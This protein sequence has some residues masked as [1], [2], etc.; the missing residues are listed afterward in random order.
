FGIMETAGKSVTVRVTLTYSYSA[1]GKLRAY[2][3]A[4]KDYPLAPNEFRQINGLAL[5]ILGSARDTLGDMKDL[6]ADFQI[7]SGDG[8]IE[9]YT[10]STDNGTGDV[11]LRTQ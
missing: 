5:D 3:A 8:R 6:E 4:Q 7:V 2:T 11:I 1:G 9:V 10:S